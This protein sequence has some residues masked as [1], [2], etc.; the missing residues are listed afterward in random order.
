MGKEG[1][2]REVKATR[3]Q[4][5]NEW[6]EGEMGEEVGGYRPLICSNS[7][8]DERFLGFSQGCRI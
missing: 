4:W 3:L 7:K 8:L 1:V 6:M 2:E 5:I